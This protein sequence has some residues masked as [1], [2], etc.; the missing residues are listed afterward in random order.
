MIEMPAVPDITLSPRLSRLTQETRLRLDPVFER[1]GS[2]SAARWRLLVMAVCA[3]WVLANLARLVW[4]ALPLGSA[5]VPANPAPVVNALVAGSPK[6]HT[7][8][9][10][11]ETMAG[12]HLFGEVGAVAKTA[13]PAAAEEQAQ[14]TTLN[15]QLL[16]LISA[17]DQSQA[18]AVIMADGQQ[19]QFAVGEQVPGNGKV[20]LN[21]VLVDRVILDNNG[22]FETLWLYDPA[23]AA[24]LGQANDVAPTPAAAATVDMRAN[25]NVTAM[26]QG[27]RQQLYQNPSSLADVIQ[28]A[29]AN[30]GGKLLGYR[31][32][33]GRDPQ[34][35]EQ[36]GFKPD[37][38][39]TSING[40]SLDDPQRS[41]ELYNVIRTAKEASFTVRR[42]SEEI[43]LVVSLD[44][45]GDGQ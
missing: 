2:V 26:A 10:D 25:S 18:R 6:A 23:T 40:I 45:A 44:K 36:F 11:I 15:L 21:K 42:G 39:V 4:I 30:E 41:L 20:V 27:Y 38:I 33:P 31:V 24:H 29:P 32:R 28:V 37:D 16:G 35:F 43:N 13:G 1:L 3:A 17:E 19:Q 7:D 8:S 9:I 12:W 14:D 22:H 34:Q 5:P